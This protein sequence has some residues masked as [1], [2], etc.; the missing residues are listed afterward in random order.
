LRKPLREHL[1]N[2]S[3]VIPSFNEEENIKLLYPKLKSVL[4][5]LKKNYEIIFVVLR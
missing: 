5:G 1:K 2:L 3:V 4:E